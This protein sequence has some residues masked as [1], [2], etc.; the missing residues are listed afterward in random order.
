MKFAVIFSVLAVLAFANKYGFDVAYNFPQSSWNCLQSQVG[1][2]FAIV[3]C[4]MSVGRV[5]PECAASVQKGWNSGLAHVDLY[6]FPCPRCGNAAKQVTDLHNY[7]TENN[8]KFGQVWLDIEGAEDYW[9]G[10]TANRQFY[11]E[12]AAT[13]KKLFGD[14]KWG[15]YTNKNGW[16]SIMGAWTPSL[17]CPLWHAFW[18]EKPSLDGFTPFDGW[19]SRAMKQYKGTT[20]YCNMGIDLNYY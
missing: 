13:T 7:V 18:D 6:M 3:R 1:M 8:V 9:M 4:Y 5:D 19:N 15:V 17:S 20:Y 2:S 11:E 12:L 10:T 14:G 16:E